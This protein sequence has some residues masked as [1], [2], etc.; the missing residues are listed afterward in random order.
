V[1][2]GQMT[3]GSL[4]TGIGGLDLGFERAGLRPAWMC[5]ADPFCRRVLAKHWPAV[6]CYDD[7]RA[8][9]AIPRR[10]VPT[11]VDAL[12]GGF[13]CQDVSNAGARRGIR[14]GERSSLWFQFERLIGE[15][16]PRYVVVENVTG[17]FV[18]GIDDVLGGLAALGYDAEWA[19][20][21]AAD[22]GA[23]HRRARVFIIA[24]R[25]ELADAEHGRGPARLGCGGSA[26]GDANADG[27]DTV[28]LAD[29]DNERCERRRLAEPAGQQGARGR[30]ADGC[31]GLRKQF[32]ASPAWRSENA[33]PP[34]A[35]FGG[36]A[37]A[38]LSRLEGAER[39]IVARPGIRRS[40][41]DA[42]GSDRGDGWPG[43]PARPGEPQHT[44]EPP[45]SIASR[46]AQSAV[47]S[48]PDGLPD[49]LARWRGTPAWRRAAL[50]ALGNAVVP[51]V[52]ELVAR[53]MLE[54]DR[55]LRAQERKAAC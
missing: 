12:I 3:F 26:P 19:V 16:G 28:A 46:R 6:P 43:W 7:V 34:L 37:H 1:E 49:G 30:V 13:P 55:A 14:R 53:R 39:A 25:R 40:D 8:L 47:G 44:W 24:W 4:F 18:R 42:T 52:A 38:E 45:R 11:P 35:A 17:L 50:Q 54:I 36:V 32:H 21:R 2:A 9:G 27:G 5:E 22:V 15:L 29:P 51:Q 31:S 33:G 41:A 48:R 23:P 10:E 20:I